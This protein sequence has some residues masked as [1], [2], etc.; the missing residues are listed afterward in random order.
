MTVNTE[1]ITRI[2]VVLAEDGRTIVYYGETADE[3]AVYVAT[4][5]LPITIDDDCFMQMDWRDIDIGALFTN[6]D[7]RQAS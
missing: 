4:I 5:M 2:S 1:A 6:L 7:W 3:D